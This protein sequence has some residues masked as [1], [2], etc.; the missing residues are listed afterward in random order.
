MHQKPDAYLMCRMSAATVA[1][2]AAFLRLRRP[3]LLRGRFQQL[4]LRGRYG[5]PG[6]PLMLERAAPDAGAGN[7]K[8]SASGGRGCV[9]RRPVGA[10]EMRKRV[11]AAFFL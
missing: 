1:V 11:A 10:A 4:K 3:L 6:L 7:S 5:L 9:H 2:I 8:S